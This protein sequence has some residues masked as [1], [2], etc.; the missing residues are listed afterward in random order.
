V[1]L[2]GRD[3]FSRVDSSVPDYTLLRPLTT[4]TEDVDAFDVTTLSRLACRDHFSVLGVRSRKVGDPLHMISNRVVRFEP[5][6]IGSS[7]GCFHISAL[8]DYSE[9]WGNYQHKH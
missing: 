2:H 1:D 3:P 6:C 9:T 7:A 8:S 4:T 5:G